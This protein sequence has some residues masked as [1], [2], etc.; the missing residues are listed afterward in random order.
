MD[1]TCLFMIKDARFRDTA[2]VVSGSKSWMK[3]E[4][5]MEELDGCQS[6]DWEPSK[7]ITRAPTAAQLSASA[8]LLRPISSSSSALGSPMG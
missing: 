7:A 8:A 6:G 3:R 2:E 5:L 1:R 4:E